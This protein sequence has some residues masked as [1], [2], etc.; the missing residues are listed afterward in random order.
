[1]NIV[2]TTHASLLVASAL[3]LGC[4]DDDGEGDTVIIDMD[5]GTFDAG[6]DADA[7]DAS[8]DA[9]GTKP[10]LDAGPAIVCS[11]TRS[12]L[13]TVANGTVSA[14]DPIALAVRNDG[15][16][17]GWISY[18]QGVRRLSTSWFSS[19]R[20]TLFSPLGDGG[21]S[22]QVEPSNVSTTAGFLSVWSDDRD[23]VDLRAQGWGPDGRPTAPE[24]IKL[25]ANSATSLESRPVLAR[26]A[27]GNILLVWQNA[28]LPSGTALLLDANGGVLGQPQTI[29]NFGPQTGQPVLAAL[30]SRYVLAWADPVAL[31]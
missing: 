11:F 14:D 2:R 27:D 3:L 6:R 19:D 16:S 28:G 8:R 25:T 10:E 29:E 31:R 12:A 9:T 21:T 24:S 13:A 23:G 22:L 26:G 1:M 30:G 20:G 17:L 18:E 4:G 5:G 7:L 15:A